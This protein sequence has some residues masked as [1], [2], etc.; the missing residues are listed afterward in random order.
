MR[1]NERHSIQ[2]REIEDYLIEEIIEGYPERRERYWDRE[3]DSIKAYR[4]SIK[5][6]RERWRDVLGAFETGIKG[7]TAEEWD[8]EEEPFL[9]TDEMEAKWI[10]PKL[11]AD[12]PLRGRGILAA[13]TDGEGSYPW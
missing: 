4:E 13:P 12:Y 6:N 3:Y 10:A 1:I 9:E 2:G 7:Q 5:S 8:V 11:F